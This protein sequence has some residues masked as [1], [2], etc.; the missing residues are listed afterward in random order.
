MNIREVTVDGLPEFVKSEEYAQLE[1]KPIT[2]LRAISQSKNPDAKKDDIALIFASENNKLVGFVGLLPNSANGFSTGI[3]SNTGWWVHP[4]IG[5]KVGLPLFLKAFQL[6]G[7]NMFFTDCTAHTK[8]ILEKTGLFVFPPPKKGTRFFFRAYFGSLIR[9]KKHVEFAGPLMSVFDGILNGF[10]SP[11][12]SMWMNK[13]DEKEHTTIF[14]DRLE[15]ELD[16]FIQKHSADK[17]LK[18]DAKKLNW[19]IQNPWV[20]SEKSNQKV[21]YPFSYLVENFRQEFLIIKKDNTV[22]SILMISVRDNHLSIPFVYFEKNS[23]EVVAKIIWHFTLK[24]K[25]NSLILYHPELLREMEKAGSPAIYKS[26]IIRYSGYSKELNSIFAGEK[27]FQ[28]GEAD[29]AFT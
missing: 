20:T 18:Q 23:L 15:P 5:K 2:W 10:M 24:N 27:I 1:P 3:F 21:E 28:D 13:F 17:Y 26:K 6:C 12:F 16:E 29:V 7:R 8:S 14:K 25:V 22:K 11:F 4:E 9:K 19:I